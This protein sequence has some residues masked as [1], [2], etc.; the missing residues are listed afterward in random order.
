MKY[1]TFLDDNGV[2]SIVTFPRFIDHDQ[3]ARSMHMGPIRSRF[4]DVE[5]GFISCAAAVVVQVGE[6]LG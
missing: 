4:M 6:G 5:V 2:E 3:M 1:I